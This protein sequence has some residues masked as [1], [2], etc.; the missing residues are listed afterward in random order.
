LISA[1]IRG[2]KV[3]LHELPVNIRNKDEERGQKKKEIKHINMGV[4][5][6]VRKI[7]KIDY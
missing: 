4:F 6:R 2:W 7:A 3:R 1:H 5:R